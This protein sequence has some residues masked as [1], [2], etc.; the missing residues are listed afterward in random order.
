VTAAPT[1]S[2]RGID[3]A[4]LAA[5]LAA[6]PLDARHRDALER[7]GQTPENIEGV[8]Y[9]SL[10]P[11]PRRGLVARLGPNAFRVRLIPEDRQGRHPAVGLRDAPPGMLVPVKDGAGQLV[12]VLLYVDPARARRSAR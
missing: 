5:L 8:G 7:A 4:P 2:L 1:G 10:P 3:P 9:R 11:P 6:C 12:A